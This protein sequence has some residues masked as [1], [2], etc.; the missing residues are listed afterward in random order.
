MMASVKPAR[1]IVI[2]VTQHFEGIKVSLTRLRKLVRTVCRRF[3][4]DD[5]LNTRGKTAKYEIGIVIV[6]N[7]QFRELNNRYLN[8]K[9]VSDCLSFDLS[10]NKE[11]YSSKLFEII[12][13][14]ELAVKQANMRGH[15]EEAELALYVTHGLLHNLGFDDSAP[16]K[17]RKMHHLEDEILQQSGY[18]LVYNKSLNAQEHKKKKK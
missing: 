2:Q 1:D 11:P 6:G 10:D 12:V 14:G 3:S 5:I 7:T 8:C 13:N 4:G 18:G 15:S 16:S 9:T 17:A